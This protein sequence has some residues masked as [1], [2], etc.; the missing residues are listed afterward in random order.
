LDLVASVVEAPLVDDLVGTAD[1]LDWN[2]NAVVVGLGTLAAL[3]VLLAVDVGAAVV[4]CSV[5]LGSS[6]SSSSSTAAPS[7]GNWGE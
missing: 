1:E 3:A 6:S 2:S 7:M 5:V 4:V